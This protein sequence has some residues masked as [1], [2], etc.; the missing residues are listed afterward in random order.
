MLE[1]FVSYLRNK[2][3]VLGEFSKLSAYCNCSECQLKLVTTESGIEHDGYLQQL[4]RGSTP[5]TVL[6]DLIFQTSRIV[7]FISPTVKTIPKIEYVRSVLERVLL[8][9]RCSANFTWDLQKEC[10]EKLAAR[11]LVNIFFNNE[12]KRTNGSVRKKNDSWFQKETKKEEV[13]ISVLNF[14]LAI[15]P[16][17]CSILNNLIMNSLSWLIL[18]NTLFHA[19][20]QCPHFI[21][22]EIIKVTFA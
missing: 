13:I 20:S 18:W 9:P 15:F 4:S 21:P 1:N 16:F 8:N 22:P 5:S 11:T 19:F 6:R 17:W 3:A 12:Q 7:Y 14:F 10:G 2:G